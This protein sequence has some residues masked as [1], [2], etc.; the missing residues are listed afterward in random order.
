MTTRDITSKLTNEIVNGIQTE[1]QVVYVLAGIRKL[2]ERDDLKEQFRA[3]N[4]HCDWTLHS[5]MDRAGARTILAIFDEVHPYLVA[6]IE[7]PKYLEFQVDRISKM[8]SFRDEFSE[9]SELFDL[10]PLTINRS[11]G[12]VHFLHLYAAVI[13]DIPL[14][15]R[16]PGE[17]ALGAG[18]DGLNHISK[19]VVTCELAPEIVKYE[20][21]REQFFTVTWTI[22]DLNGQSGRLEVFNSFSAK[23]E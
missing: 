1:A 18:V 17:R 6:G 9:F 19:V 20:E 12:W 13:A 2:I 5:T 16:A 8:R 10:P 15:V 22:Y 4:F 7:L 23:P 3:L 14:T 11:D 21:F